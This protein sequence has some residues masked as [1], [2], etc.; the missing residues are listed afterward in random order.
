MVTLYKSAFKEKLLDGFT[1]SIDDDPYDDS[2]IAVT[3]KVFIR[4][5]ESRAE[6]NAVLKRAYEPRGVI[7]NG[8]FYLANQDST[9]VIHEEI[10]RFLDKK[11]LVDFRDIDYANE[12]DRFLTVQVKN[13]KVYIGE[14]YHPEFKAMVRQGGGGLPKY[15]MVLDH[16][17]V[18]ENI[19]IPYEAKFI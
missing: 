10:L 12:V 11:S 14:S 7:T 17:S 15:Q 18:L 16:L 5:I 1:L 13:K 6:Y 3:H 19:G 2:G 9:D 4:Q 8:K